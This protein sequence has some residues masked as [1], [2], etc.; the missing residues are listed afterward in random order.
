[1]SGIIFNSESECC[2]NSLELFTPPF[3]QLAVE[4]YFVTELLPSHPLSNASNQIVFDA[5]VSEEFTDL[6]ETFLQVKVRIKNADNTNIA[7]FAAPAVADAAAANSVGFVNLALSSLFS[8]LDVKINGI[9]VNSNFFTYGYICYLQSILNY[10]QDSLNSKLAL[11]GWYT[12]DDLSV[13]RADDGGIISSGFYKRAQKTRTSREWTLLGNLHNP[14]TMQNRYLIPLIPLS[15]VLTKAGPQFCLQSNA[16]NPT[17]IYEITSAK[18]FLKRVKVLSTYKLKIETQLMRSNAIYPLRTFDCRPYSLDAS[19]KSFTFE[20]IFSGNSTIP[21]YCV[22][23]LVSQQDFSGRYSTSPYL[24][25]HFSLEEISISFDQHRFA[26]ELK[27]DDGPIQD[28]SSSYNA[29][30][31]ISGCKSDSGISISL[32]KYHQG[33]ALYSWNFG[34]D[35]SMNPDQWNNKVTGSARLSLKFSSTS[36]NEA[37]VVLVYSEENQILQINSKREVIRSYNI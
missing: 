31:R 18:I 13:N 7:A 25:N 21:D 28:Y 8:G 15:F 6:D 23:G 24:F 29:L 9:S 32:E 33:F 20:N 12:D 4:N 14:L 5:P 22:I 37:L 26:Y 30:F 17:F 36:D 10:G 34:R 2:T 35:N 11:S 27:Y 16:A 3:H 19:V 1:M